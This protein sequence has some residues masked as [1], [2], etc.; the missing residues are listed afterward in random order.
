MCVHNFYNCKLLISQLL[1]FSDYSVPEVNIIDSLHNQLVKNYATALASDS[2]VQVYSNVYFPSNKGLDRKDWEIDLIAIYSNENKIQFYEVK[3]S[4]HENARHKAYLQL[5]RD[6]R[7][8]LKNFHADII[9]TYFISPA[10]IERVTPVEDYINGV[11]SYTSMR[12]IL[13]FS[14][15]KKR[16]NILRKDR[17]ELLSDLERVV[18][19]EVFTFGIVDGMTVDL[20][21]SND[22]GL[23]IYKVKGSNDD[24]IIR[25]GVGQLVRNAELLAK[26]SLVE[27]VQFYLV[28]PDGVRR[29]SKAE[30]Q[31]RRVRTEL[32]RVEYLNNEPELGTINVQRNL[33]QS[34]ENI[35]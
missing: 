32:A 29:V 14:D 31:F 27:N 23:E 11:I 17:V 15:V 1:D 5:V 33:E 28:T 25:R 13:G 12:N 16:K 10:G 2:D 30:R 8:W 18:N 34:L 22:S 6:A 3:E 35:F 21:V 19:G 9:E 26:Y 4:S 20:M 7:L 24:R